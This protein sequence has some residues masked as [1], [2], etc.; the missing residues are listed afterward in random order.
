MAQNQY[1]TID[2]VPDG[3]PKWM[4]YKIKLLL[5]MMMITMSRT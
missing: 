5:T 1:L 3:W 4:V 2:D